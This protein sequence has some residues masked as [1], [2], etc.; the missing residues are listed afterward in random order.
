MCLFKQRSL[1]HRR[2]LILAA[3][4]ASL[5]MRRATPRR[6]TV[7]LWAARGQAGPDASADRRGGDVGHAGPA[8][9]RPGG[10]RR[11]LGSSRSYS[12]RQ[13][14][15]RCCR[16][17]QGLGALEMCSVDS[18][19][20]VHAALEP[21]FGSQGRSRTYHARPP[22]ESGCP[23]V[24]PCRA[25]PSPGAC[26]A[27]DATADCEPGPRRARRCPEDRRPA[28]CRPVVEQRTRSD[29]W[30][31]HDATGESGGGDEPRLGAA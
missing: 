10:A 23:L 28:R 21:A 22:S 27:T 7:Q 1:V 16:H 9:V 4:R 2:C 5:F 12:H 15:R 3:R 31:L 24:R 18:G 25:G 17:Q 14:W 30:K 20:G 26:G 19:T 13:P 6:Q 11:A 8:L 29:V